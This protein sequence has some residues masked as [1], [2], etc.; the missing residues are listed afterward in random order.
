ML[1]KKLKERIVKSIS[2]RLALPHYRVFI[3]GSRVTGNAKSRSDIDIGIESSE[4]IPLNIINDIK[5]ELD[6]IPILQK[7][8][9][10]DFKV[11]DDDFRK[12]AL[13]NIEVIYEQ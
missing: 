9:V 8:D 5:A 3:F 7:I 11:V 13:K 12:V 10:V 4:P 6:E 1:D 2:W